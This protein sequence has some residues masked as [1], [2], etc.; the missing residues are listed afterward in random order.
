[1]SPGIGDPAQS[2]VAWSFG[3]SPGDVAVVTG[4]ASGIGRA[5][6]QLLAHQGLVVVGWD[7]DTERLD[8]LVREIASTGG[9]CHPVTCD[10]GETAAVEAAWEDTAR[11]GVASYLVNNAGPPSSAPLGV[12]DGI[13]QAAAS[14]AFVGDSWLARAGSDAVAMTVT[15]SI[16]GTWAAGGTDDWYPMAKAAIASYGRQVAARCKGRPRAN[17]VAPGLTDTPRMAAFM[18]SDIGRQLVARSPMRRAARPEE[19]AAA[20]AFLLSPAASFVN[21]ATLVVDGGSVL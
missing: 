4:A 1:M 15:S 10:V 11:H 18:T 17:V 20:I 14:M 7:I 6:A 21:G 16:A 3:F 2:P 5:T 9:T 8:E 19:V 12:A 13:V